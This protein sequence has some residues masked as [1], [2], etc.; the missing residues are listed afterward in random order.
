MEV[1]EELALADVATYLYEKL[2][3]YDQME[4]AFTTS[5]L[6]LASLEQ[7]ASRRDDIIERLRNNY[8]SAANS[9]APIFLTVN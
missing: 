7:K 8:V 2:K 3:M 1:F 6:K 4:T 9:A 5:D